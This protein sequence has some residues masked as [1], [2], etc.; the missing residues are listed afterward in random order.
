MM[1]DASS[2]LSTFL[3]AGVIV[4]W[5]TALMLIWLM[6]RRYAQKLD[7]L[8]ECSSEE[9]L[10]ELDSAFAPRG[11]V[12]IRTQTE[13]LPFLIEALREETDRG[14]DDQQ[15]RSLIERIDHQRPHHERRAVFHV[16]SHGVTSNLSLQ[17]VRDDEDRIELKVHAAP[18]IV[19][20][21]KNHKK[22]IPRAK[23]SRVKG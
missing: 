5:P 15:V 19:R 13:Y 3:I 14:L 12:T 2:D 23:R 20:A 11:K 21:L 8:G 17:W 1:D 10:E 18:E 22:T 7:R 16:E 9:M 4:V 6:K